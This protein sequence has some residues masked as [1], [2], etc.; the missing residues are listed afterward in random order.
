MA[1]FVNEECLTDGKI[2]PIK[3]NPIVVM[4]PSY[5]ELG[6]AIGAVYQ[7]GM[8]YKKSLGI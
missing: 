1:V 3:T 5:F 8:A 4:Y 6:K 7:D 2:D